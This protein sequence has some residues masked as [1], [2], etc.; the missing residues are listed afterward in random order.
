MQR[1]AVW[2]SKP[3]S[4]LGNHLAEKMNHGKGLG[5]SLVSYDLYKDLRDN[6]AGFAELAAF[7][8]SQVVFGVRRADRTEAAQSYPGEFVSARITADK[9]LAGN[10][11]EA[12][13][14]SQE[15]EV[16][17]PSNSGIPA[18]R[19]DVCSFWRIVAPSRH[20]IEDFVSMRRSPCAERS[21]SN[22]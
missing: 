4:Q 3:S 2:I 8:A 22:Q 13:G 1:L 16:E 12:Q 14:R 18:Q 11:G 19:G 9:R 21:G 17:E 6:T 7:Q 20:S 5:E 10:V 15:C